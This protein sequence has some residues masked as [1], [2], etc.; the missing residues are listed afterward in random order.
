MIPTTET[1]TVP[2]PGSRRPR[3]RG[4]SALVFVVAGL[5]VGVYGF[6]TH[7]GHVSPITFALAMV[8]F[9]GIGIL[10]YLKQRARR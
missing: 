8:A 4:I 9:V 5:V 10:V 7:P 3:P 6:I 1:F 2:E